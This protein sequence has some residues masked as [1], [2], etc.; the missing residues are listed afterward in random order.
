MIVPGSY[1]GYKIVIS[2]QKCNEQNCE[3]CNFSYHALF[4]QLRPMAE[5][6]TLLLSVP[7]RE[8]NSNR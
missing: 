3:D 2:E 7:V 4:G 8:Q 6:T 5:V 1:N